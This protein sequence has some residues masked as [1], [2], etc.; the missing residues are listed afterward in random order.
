MSRE[1]GEQARS[2][3]PRRRDSRFL[4]DAERDGTR[5]RWAHDKYAEPARVDEPRQAKPKKSRWDVGDPN[6][7]PVDETVF[8]Y[9]EVRVPSHLYF[10]TIFNVHV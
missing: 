8:K 4:L 6:K 5:E 9:Y 10:N 3:S 1:E 7:K 2:R